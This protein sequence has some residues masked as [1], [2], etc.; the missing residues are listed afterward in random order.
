MLPSGA[1]F[2]I[3]ISAVLLAAIL[4]WVVAALYR[5]GML[6]L[7][8]GGSTP[9]SAVPIAASVTPPDAHPIPQASAGRAKLAANRQATIR[10]MLVL[11]GISLLIALTQSLLALLFVYGEGELRLSRVL[12]LGAVYAWPMVLAWGLA[13]CWSWLRVLGGI[14]AYM[15]AMLMLVMAR[16]T[17][18]QTLASVSSWLGSQVA[19]PMTIALLIGASGRIRA[20]A[21]YL[22]P[23]TLLLTGSSVLTLQIMAQGSPDPAP[24][25]MGLVHILGAYPTLFLF[26]IGP[27]LILSWPVFI[28]GKWLASAYRAKRF[29]DLI[30]LIATYWFLILFAS[31]LTAMESVGWLAFVELLALLWLPLVLLCLRNALKPPPGPPTLLVLRVFQRDAQVERLFDQVIERWR[32]TGNT[33][34]IAGTD[35]LSRTLD[36]DDLFI[37]LNGALAERFIARPDQVNER[38]NGF[39]WLPDPDGRYRINECYC[40]DSTWQIALNI[41]V[42]RADVV[43]MDLRGF[44][45]ENHG[46]RYELGVLA[47]DSHLHRVVLLYDR[48]TDRAEAQS[49]IDE[50]A[51]GRFTWLSADRM[52]STMAHRVLSALFDPVD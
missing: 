52:D 8:R 33:V 23:P 51:A 21:P 15:A 32:L 3:L 5:R 22:L 39:D 9:A 18:A 11:S 17:E 35:L 43:L 36:P 47:R 31:A 46:C 42:A 16:S 49:E 29:S 19:I 12:L 7:M 25:V 20:V 44:H 10:L 48:V 37:Y 6:A 41:L 38:L 24:W 27:W 50:P 4:A 26:A 1:V 14:G 34:L 45:A 28:L 13:R 30:Y 40:F 2:F